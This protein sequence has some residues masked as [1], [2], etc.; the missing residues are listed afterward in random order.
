MSQKQG[1]F[2]LVFTGKAVFR[3]S[4]LL[5]FFKIDVFN[6]F[7]IFTGNTCVGVSYR[8]ILLKKRPQHW[9]FPANIAKFLRTVFFKK[10]TSPVAVSNATLQSPQRPSC[11]GLHNIFETMWTDVKIYGP[12]WYTPYFL[13]AWKRI[14]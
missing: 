4:H 13:R 5:M 2:I 10:A 9:C 7:A 11:S 6:N 1:W 12:C 8:F 3:N 14:G